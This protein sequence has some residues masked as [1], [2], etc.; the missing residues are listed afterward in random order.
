MVQSRSQLVLIVVVGGAVCKEEMA[1]LG[2]YIKVGRQKSARLKVMLVLMVQFWAQLVLVVWL[3]ALR[4]SVQ[5]VQRKKFRLGSVQCAKCESVKSVQGVQRKKSKLGRSGQGRRFN[6]LPPPPPVV[7]SCCCFIYF[8]LLISRT[9]IE[10]T[11]KL[12]ISSKWTKRAAHS[13]SRSCSSGWTN[14]ERP[15]LQCVTT[16]RQIV[17][18]H[19][20]V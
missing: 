13:G 3:R 18:P 16:L 14:Q 1:K 12:C 20:L 7:T 10:P 17:G 6:S 11:K 4:A 19:S 15:K 8:L 5:G 2:M 9:T